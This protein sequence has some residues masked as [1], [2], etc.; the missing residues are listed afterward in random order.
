MDCYIGEI[1]PFA[2][3]IVP[4]G[5]HL[6]D[7]TLLTI[8]QNQALYAL[9]GTTYGSATGQ[10]ALPDFRG[11][12]PVFTNYQSNYKMGFMGGT[13]AV[14]LNASQVPMHS[15]AMEVANAPGVTSINTNRLAI[16]TSASTV[17]PIVTASIYTPDASQN[18]NLAVN[19]LEYAG[20]NNVHNNLQP[21]QT[22]NYCIAL[23]GYWPPRE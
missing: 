8:Q 20:N 21:Y 10:F 12:T 9:I 15:H 1:R 11:R 18:T 2:F 14:A 6:C 3:G 23:Q 7:G 16:P 19:T 17:T 13:E 22:V 5:W 4:S